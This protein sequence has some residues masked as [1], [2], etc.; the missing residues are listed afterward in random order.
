MIGHV[1]RT[2]VPAATG[3]PAAVRLSRVTR[4][5]D[6]LAAVSQVSLEIA[7]GETVWLR[8]WNGSGKTTLLR[9]IATAITPTYGGGTV[10]GLD[11]QK[12]RNAVRART[13][14]LSHETRFYN[15]LTATENLQF[16]CSLYGL[17]KRR[18]DG[19]LDR[20][21]LGEVGTVRVGSFSQGM[22]QRLALARCLMRAPTLVLL[23][24]PY[25]A[26]D[27]EARI[28]VDDL[29]AAAR[30]SGQTVIVASHEAPPPHLVDRD[31][32]MDGGR[33][34][35]PNGDDVMSERPRANQNCRASGGPCAEAKRGR[36]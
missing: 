20:V 12:R 34:V 36:A 33:V 26:L 8:G 10:F 29:I 15:D 27:S 17:D 25:A 11:L 7:A 19:S 16:A 30:T 23:D 13:D 4:L 14:L 6:G 18:V 22:R 31:V 28:V 1:A 24:E 32:I 35:T 21:G 5:F 2:S 9:V 3:R